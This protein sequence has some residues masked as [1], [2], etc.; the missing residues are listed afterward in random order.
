MIAILLPTDECN[1][2][3]TYCH[4]RK[5]HNIMS[6]KT[7]SNSV[8]FVSNTFDELHTGGH[9]EWHASEPLLRPISFY[10]R[11]EKMFED[12]GCVQRRVMCTNLTLLTM[13]WVNFFKKYHYS[14]STS[15]DGDRYLHDH[16]C[17]A[18][19]FD[20]VIKAMAMLKEHNIPYGNIAV[21]S[22]HSAN[23][24]DE[25]YPFF[26]YA[27]L[28]FKLN[29]QSPNTFKSLSLTAM[30]HVF[31]DWWND[32]NAISV[33]P[34]NS[35]VRFFIRRSGECRC[36]AVCSN[37]I[38]AIDTH[39]DVYPCETFVTS[40]PRFD[41]YRFGNVNSDSWEDIW[42]GDARMKFLTFL[43]NVSDECRR[44]PYFSYCG[45]GCSYESIAVGNTT[46]K[47]GTTC[48]IIRPLMDHIGDRVGW[49]GA[50]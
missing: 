14:V 5:G 18:G 11:A 27:N 25:I 45:G 12:R 43:D 42:F 26:K 30:L 9:V 49:L 32:K 4:A 22:E 46:T 50:V 8:D 31:E 6:E 16:N 24:A 48:E 28:D 7:L 39:G 23:H 40:D 38:F 44:C 41:E 19:S 37:N 21:L 10:E 34:F 17:G 1:L 36:S 35:M 29:I 2:N 47:M 33:D 13:E 3:C 20:A 15:L